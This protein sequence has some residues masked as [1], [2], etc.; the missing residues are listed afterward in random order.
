MRTIQFEDLATPTLTQLISRKESFE[1]VGLGGRLTKAVSLVENK[2]ESNAMTCRAYTVGRI[3]AAAG[4]FFGGITGAIGVVSAAGIAIHN[5][6]TFNPDYEIEKY[7][8]DNRL[9]VKYKK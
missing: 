6:L 8:I 9:I 7:P 1:V 4:S 3:G 5:I 2:I